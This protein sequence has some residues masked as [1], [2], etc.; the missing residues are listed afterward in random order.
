[1]IEYIYGNLIIKESNYCIID[2]NGIGYKVSITNN[3]YESLPTIKE[4]VNLLI[5]FHVLL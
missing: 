1:M 4:R 3:T 2:V 5:F